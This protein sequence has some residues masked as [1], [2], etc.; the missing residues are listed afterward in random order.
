MH[1]YHP[2]DFDIWESSNNKLNL[3]S[4]EMKSGYRRMS[5]GVAAIFICADQPVTIIFRLRQSGAPYIYSGLFLT[6]RLDIR[7]LSYLFY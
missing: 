4:I 3:H 6:G 2:I 5:P 1:C 7:I